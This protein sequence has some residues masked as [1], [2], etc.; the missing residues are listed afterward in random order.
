M[1]PNRIYLQSQEEFDKVARLDL[2]TGEFQYLSKSENDEVWDYPKYGSFGR[3]GQHL[4]ALFRT[5]DGLHIQV[6]GQTFPVESSVSVEWSPPQSIDSRATFSLKKH[7][8]ELLY[9]AYRPSGEADPVTP[10]SEDD[11]HDFPQFIAHVLGD[12]RRREEIYR[13]PFTG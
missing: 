13:E 7:G 8:R 9:I 6:D 3:A 1:E 12:S 2:D 4:V 10:F 11:D 5:R